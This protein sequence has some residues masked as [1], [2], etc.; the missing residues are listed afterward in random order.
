MIHSTDMRK[1][2]L[3]VQVLVN[4]GTQTGQWLMLGCNH[5]LP[6]YYTLF[7]ACWP[8]LVSIGL[9]GFCLIIIMVIGGFC[10][11]WYLTGNWMTDQKIALFA[12]NH[13]NTA[14]RE[15]LFIMY[16]DGVL[17]DCYHSIKLILSI[18]VMGSWLNGSCN[19]YYLPSITYMQQI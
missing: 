18:G 12:T 14:N 15:L 8:W 5:L 1:S 13:L 19:C 17:P 9:M 3:P 11:G 6:R 7:S 10:R 16:G 4:Y 2:L